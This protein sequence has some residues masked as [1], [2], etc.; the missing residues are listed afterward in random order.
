M[1]EIVSGARLPQP[2][3]QLSYWPRYA[4]REW[5]EKAGFPHNDAL[6]LIVCTAY[7][8]MHRLV[9]DVHYLSCDGVGDPPRAT[10]EQPLCDEQPQQAQN[11]N[12][13]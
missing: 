5:M 10:T 6:S 7:D 9:V 4:L 13:H 12:K 11:Q 2:T 1:P 8:A 3:L